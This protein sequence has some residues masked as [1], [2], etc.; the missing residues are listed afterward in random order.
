MNSYRLSKEAEQD[1]EDLWVYL[2]ERERVIYS[3]SIGGCQPTET[4]ALRTLT[5]MGLLSRNA[6]T[7]ARP[8]AVCP[9]I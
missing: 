9:T 6:I 7:V 3:S 8:Q 4:H 1:L 5:E 2:G